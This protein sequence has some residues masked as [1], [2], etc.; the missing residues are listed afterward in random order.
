VV[1]DTRRRPRVPLL[2]EIMDE[3][4]DVVLLSDMTWHELY[5]LKADLEAR[6]P[7]WVVWYVPRA[8]GGTIWAARRVPPARS[9]LTR[10]A[11][12]ANP[13]CGALA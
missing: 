4:P 12:G 9:G 11:G 13:G 8:V 1:P 10:A 5:R 7:G 3:S 6:F 2:S